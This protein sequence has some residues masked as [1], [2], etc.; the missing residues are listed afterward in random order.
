[1]PLTGVQLIPGNSNRHN[2]SSLHGVVDKDPGAGSFA[3]VR[4]DTVEASRAIRALGS[5]FRQGG[6]ALSRI[7]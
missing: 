1:M 5:G 6:A 7:V 2:A 3:A 4:L